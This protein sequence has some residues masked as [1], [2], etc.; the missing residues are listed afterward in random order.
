MKMGSRPVP[1]S[2]EPY[3]DYYISSSSFSN[4]AAIPRRKTV[5]TPDIELD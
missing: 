2:I 4:F 3:F 5:S 1:A